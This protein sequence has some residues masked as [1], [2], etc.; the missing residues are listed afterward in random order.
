M[1]L[2]QEALAEDITHKLRAEWMML[3]EFKVILN[4]LH[5]TFGIFRTASDRSYTETF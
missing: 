2:E 5:D 3:G 4:F 1:S